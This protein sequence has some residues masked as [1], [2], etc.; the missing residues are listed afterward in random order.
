[1]EH[2]Q[3]KLSIYYDGLCTMCTA[4]MRKLQDSSQGDSF[5]MAD[6]TKGERPPGM[7]E[8]EALHSMHVID[9]RGVTYKGG[10]AVIRILAQYPRWRWFARIAGLPG[11]R[12]IVCLLYRFVATHRRRFNSLVR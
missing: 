6:V 9:E 1:M 8:D 5:H 7:G 12:R 11:V 3:E 4:T 2:R 10:A